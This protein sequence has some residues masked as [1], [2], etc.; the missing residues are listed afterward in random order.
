MSSEKYIIH[1]GQKGYDRLLILS[2]ERWPD[3][4]ALF[5]RVG[6]RAG[7][8]CLDVGCGGGEVSIE[9]AKLVAPNG[10]VTGI[11]MDGVK[12]DLGRAAARQRGVG[13]VHFQER[14]VNDWDEPGRYDLVYSRFLLHHLRQP[15]QLLRRMW[16]AV[17]SGGALVMEDADFG[18]WSCDPPNEA[19]D[20]FLR[21]YQEV[22]RKHG[23]DPTHGRKLRRHF[24]EAGIPEPDL[25]LVQSIYT[26]G[27][28]KTLALSTLEG[29]SEA[30]VAAGVATPEQVSAALSDL[31]KFTADPLTLMTGPRLFQAWTRR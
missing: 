9:L 6:V 27:E 15:V 18:G 3:T 20:F 21:T 24:Q 28:A 10:T 5:Q 7:M 17:R 23:G 25:K 8:E 13:N 14:N 11:D 16:A 12:L 2:R 30:I 4:L 22:L 1:G 26:T 19:F 31:T 29:T